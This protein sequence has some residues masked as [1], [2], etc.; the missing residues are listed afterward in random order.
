MFP[1]AV[2]SYPCWH[3][4][5]SKTRTGLKK[6]TRLHLSSRMKLYRSGF[7]YQGNYLTPALWA[8]WMGA[9]PCVLVQIHVRTPTQQKTFNRLEMYCKSCFVC[10]CFSVWCIESWTS[11]LICRQSAQ[12]CAQPFPGFPWGGGKR[13]WFLC[14]TPP[15]PD[16]CTNFFFTGL[17]S[18]FVSS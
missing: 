11:R 12:I 14:G 8:G 5:A 3:A 15:L 10:Q 13:L 9:E 2:Y 16:T 17:Y 18:S 1:T 7:N 6:T 4:T